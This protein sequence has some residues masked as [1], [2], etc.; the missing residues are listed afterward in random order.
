LIIIIV[1]QIILII[2]DSKTIQLAN[3][4][5]TA[6]AANGSGITVGSNDNIATFLYNSSTNSWT[7]NLALTYANG[8]PIG[9]SVHIGET[10]LEVDDGNLWWNS[11]DGRGY[12]KYDDQWIEFCP[13]II[14]NPSVYLGNLVIDNNQLIL[15]TG[16]NIT[17]GD[18]S[19]QTTAYTGGGGNVDLTNV[20]SNIIPSANLTYSLGNS[21]RWWT[22]AWFSSNTVYIGGVAL[23][24]GV[25]VGVT[26]GVGVY[27]GVI[28]GVT[29]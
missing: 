1:I 4:A 24:V 14:P 8:D 10:P 22:N 19:I 11:D 12:I 25:Y 6:N 3:T 15:P 28:L 29:V 17:F 2:T 21:T 26:L 27:V 16:G 5:S 18:G 20:S 7:T 23:G 13:P 9:T